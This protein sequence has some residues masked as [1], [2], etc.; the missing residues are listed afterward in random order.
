[1]SAK[2]YLLQQAMMGAP[3]FSFSCGV[4]VRISRD[5][6]IREGLPHSRMRDVECDV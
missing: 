2:L 6:A 3:P 5:V 4:I 1:M